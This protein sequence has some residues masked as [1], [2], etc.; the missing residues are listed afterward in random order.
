[1]FLGIYQVGYAMRTIPEPPAPESF[2]SLEGADPDPPPPPPVFWR[3]SPPFVVVVVPPPF[4][5]PA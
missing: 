4:H 2:P 1:M 5:P 3:A